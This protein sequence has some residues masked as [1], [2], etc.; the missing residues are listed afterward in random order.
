M[1]AFFSDWLFLPDMPTQNCLSSFGLYLNFPLP[2]DSF[3]P[4]FHSTQSK[5]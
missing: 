3:T 4:L 5:K 1:L 2:L